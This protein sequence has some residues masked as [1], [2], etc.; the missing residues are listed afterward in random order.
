[1]RCSNLFCFLKWGLLYYSF[2]TWEPV[3]AEIRYSIPEELQRG[4]FIGNIAADLSLDVKQLANR[5]FRLV[6]G[7]RKQYLEVNLNNGVLFVKEKIDRE[8][9]CGASLTCVLS[10]EAVLE[11]PLN[12][13]QIEVDILDINDNSPSFPKSQ[14]RLKISELTAPGARF[15]LESAH[16]PDI[17]TNSVRTYE[18]MTNELFT[19]NVEDGIADWKLPVL[20]LEQPLD[21]EKHSTHRLLLQAKDGGVPERSGA[22]QINVVVEDAND[23]APVFSRSVYTTSLV[24]NTTKGALV[25]QIN[26]TDLD[27]GANGEIAYSFS[28]R[29]SARVREIFGMDS[30]TGEIKLKANL[31]YEQNSVFDIMVQAMDK[32]SNAIPVY[33]RILLTILDVNDNA[34]EITLTSLSSPVPEDALPG[35]VVALIS[36]S[37]RDSG[38]NGRVQC[39][40]ETKVPFTLESSSKNH[41]RLLTHDALDREYVSTHNVTIICRDEGTPALSTIRTIP[42]EVS[43]RNDNSPQ[44]SQSSFTV[45][46]MENNNIGA[47]LASMTAFDPDVGENARLSYDILENWVQGQ[48]ISNYV[49]INSESGNIYSYKTFDYEQLK[50]FHIQVEARDHGVPSRHGNVSVEVIILDQNDNAPV[51]VHPLFEYGSTTREVVSRSAEAGYPVTK[52]TSTDADSGQNARLCY[53]ILHATDLGLF[54]ISEDTG[55]IWTTRAISKTDATKQ[56]LVIQVNDN[57]TP[58]LSAS[59]TV[60]LSLV[61]G[62][63]A[64]L[65]DRGSLVQ[66][67]NV[68]SVTSFY[69]VV[70]LGMLS[71]I[72]LVILVILAIK[73]HKSRNVFEDHCCVLGAC[74][75]FGPRHSLNGVQ[76]ASRNLQIAP[77]YVEV[78]GGD[79]L[80]QSYR[81]QTCSMARSAKGDLVF[82]NTCGS[83]KGKNKTPSEVIAQRGAAVF[84]TCENSVHSETTDVH[85]PVLGKYCSYFNV[86]N[87]NDGKIISEAA[88]GKLN[89][90]SIR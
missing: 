56:K 36:A 70:S 25:L 75:S 47:L 51:I 33:S 73:V 11:S 77:N 65:S 43:D 79:P 39:H 9:L 71:F 89:Q 52:V 23:N 27:D 69:L 7:Q 37:D 82:P 83:W 2:I 26:A 18:L 17:G 78:F 8:E 67:S 90:R 30:Q 76:K 54:T 21:R 22:T 48:S 6:S 64:L 66:R 24:E 3:L 12:L 87:V 85:S 32:G 14:A 74:F 19:L 88:F 84:K 16:D 45:H 35:T 62:E 13:Y 53:R 55:E 58:A 81:Y 86:L 49:Y 44:F 41:L 5:N 15:P 31:D 61:D 50:S 63:E 1:M 59:I 42:I 38:N 29:T 10:L 20:V 28:S 57:G 40:I 4:A 60:I 80:S 34:P 46:V 68:A 72:F